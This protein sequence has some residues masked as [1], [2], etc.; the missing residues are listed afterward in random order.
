[1]MNK[2]Y[3]CRMSIKVNLP[4]INFVK[5]R[6]SQ[7]KT[8]IGDPERPII[9][10]VNNISIS[11]KRNNLTP[12]RNPKKTIN[13]SIIKCKFKADNVNHAC[14]NIVLRKC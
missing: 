5:P 10:A 12:T 11:T 3:E 2:M 6:F 13:L 14:Q 7:R 4:I 1:M 8:P 9:V